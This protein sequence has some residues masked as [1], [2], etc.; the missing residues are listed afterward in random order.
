M[1]GSSLASLL[2]EAIQSHQAQPDPEGSAWLDALQTPY[3]NTMAGIGEG[4]GDSNIYGQMSVPTPGL[5]GRGDVQQLEKPLVK[6]DGV[7]NLPP[8]HLDARTLV[9][10]LLRAKAR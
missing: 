10:M 8:S 4:R 3:N 6:D 5:R 9:Q 2:L 1:P 7:P